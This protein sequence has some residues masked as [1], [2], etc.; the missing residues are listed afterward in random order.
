MPQSPS[1][2][3]FSAA[4]LALYATVVLVWGTSWLPLR[5]QLGVVAPEVSGLWRFA[6][7][8][9][10][11][12]AWVGLAGARFR[13][14]GADHAR[15]ALLGA[16]LFSLNFLA[17]YYGGFYLSSG[18]LAVVFSLA[19][20][21]NPLLAAAL[22]RGVLD[23]RV[24]TAAVLGVGGIALLFGPEITA[25]EASRDTALGLGLALL[26]TV[27]FCI[28]NMLSAA[29]QAR[30]MPVVP[31][32]AWCMLYGTAVFAAVALVRGEPFI[33]EWNARYLGS[34]AW[35]ALLSTVVAFFAYLTLVGRVGPGR[36]SYSTVLVPLMALAIS[37]V[38][39]HYTW[40]AAGGL[41]VILVLAGNAVVLSAPR[42]A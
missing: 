22:G 12:F 25:T 41:G 36:A 4:D 27:L 19:S 33:A 30:G 28:G 17:A 3:A 8:A 38:F 5:L 21:I 20:I 7:A 11:M 39:E 6:I 37:T 29:F 24:L 35:L 31:A 23:L 32:N 16:T 18:L 34:V 14:G 42:R 1:R 2:S 9:T 13:F 26:A 10:I 15:F 40:T